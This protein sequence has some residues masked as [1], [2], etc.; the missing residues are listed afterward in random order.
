VNE[1]E[2]Q[3]SGNYELEFSRRY[4]SRDMASMPAFAD[5]ENQILMGE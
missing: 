3:M 1:V 5:E 4:A 2:R